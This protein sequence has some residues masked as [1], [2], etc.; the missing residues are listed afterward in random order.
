MASQ[1]RRIKTCLIVIGGHISFAIT[2]RRSQARTSASRDS[3]LHLEE[4]NPPAKH[5]KT[6]KPAVATVKFPNLQKSQQRKMLMGVAHKSAVET[7]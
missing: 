7:M 6:P 1:Y 3:Y 2:Y 4:A 5:T